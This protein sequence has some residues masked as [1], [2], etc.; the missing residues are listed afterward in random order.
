MMNPEKR[1]FLAQKICPTPGFADICVSSRGKK[2]TIIGCPRESSPTPMMPRM[3]RIGCKRDWC[4]IVS[5][6]HPSLHIRKCVLVIPL[7]SYLKRNDRCKLGHNR[8][9][10]HILAGTTTEI[11]DRSSASATC[12][13]CLLSP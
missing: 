3:L 6:H 5:P 1:R 9:N 12:P 4:A 13:S 7:T 2:C 11:V 10:E 8:P